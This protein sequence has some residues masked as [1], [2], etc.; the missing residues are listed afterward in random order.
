M[1]SYNNIFYKLLSLKYKLKF[2]LL[3][4]KT[5][6]KKTSN[7]VSMQ[8]ILV[9]LKKLFKKKFIKD[10]LEISGKKKVILYA[11]ETTTQ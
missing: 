9:L 1:P 2:K 3:I 10:Y 4:F 8:K 7:Y 11:S 6:K 5:K